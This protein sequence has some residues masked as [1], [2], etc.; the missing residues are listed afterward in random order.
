MP[1]TSCLLCLFS[2]KRSISLA[3]AFQRNWKLQKDGMNVVQIKLTFD[4]D[5]GET[6]H[7]KSDW[8]RSALTFDLRYQWL[9]WVTAGLHSVFIVNFINIL[10]HQMVSQL[11]TPCP[12]GWVTISKGMQREKFSMPEE[13]LL[14]IFHGQTTAWRWLIKINLVKLLKVGVGKEQ[15]SPRLLVENY[16]KIMKTNF[17]AIC[18]Q[19]ELWH[20][21]RCGGDGMWGVRLTKNQESNWKPV[22]FRS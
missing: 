3:T 14:Q 10:Y 7:F 4:F 22:P 12:R 6:R 2:K 8:V 17:Y 5:S 21:Q 13:T 15:S 18:P 1:S 11:K 16:V 20:I 9:F 19:T